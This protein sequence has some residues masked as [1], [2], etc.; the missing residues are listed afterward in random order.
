MLGPLDI[1]PKAAGDPGDT[2]GHARRRRRA[3]DALSSAAMLVMAVRREVQ[4]PDN[5]WKLETIQRNLALTLADLGADPSQL[6]SVS[7]GVAEAGPTRSQA[8]Q[9]T[10]VNDS[11]SSLTPSE[12]RVLKLLA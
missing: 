10:R 3:V 1:E 8:A 4:D 2:R 11:T 7:P 9:E 12:T 6:L 5:S